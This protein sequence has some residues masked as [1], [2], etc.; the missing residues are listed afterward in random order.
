MLENIICVYKVEYSIL[1]KKSKENANFQSD[2]LHK[3]NPEYEYTLPQKKRNFS[4][5]AFLL[6]RSVSQ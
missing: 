3:I 1:E 6:G 2:M 5:G 4:E